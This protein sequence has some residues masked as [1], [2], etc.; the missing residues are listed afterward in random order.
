LG[1]F[2]YQKERRE[3][4]NLSQR[5]RETEKKKWGD[6][7]IDREVEEGKP[8]GRVTFGERIRGKK[9]KEKKFLKIF[10]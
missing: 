5:V 4:E 7:T 1:C 8:E 9:Q 10:G 2:P 3:R 6:G